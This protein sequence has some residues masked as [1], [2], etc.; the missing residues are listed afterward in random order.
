[1]YH[2]SLYEAL[3][4]ATGYLRDYVNEI[5]LFFN[6]SNEYLERICHEAVSNDIRTNYCILLCKVVCFSGCSKY[7]QNHFWIY[8]GYFLAH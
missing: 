3:R 2:W 5:E 4:R 8:T 1:M 7:L 6:I